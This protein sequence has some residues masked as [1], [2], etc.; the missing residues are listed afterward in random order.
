MAKIIEL[1]RGRLKV[2]EIDVTG[3]TVKQIVQLMRC[4]QMIGRTGKYRCL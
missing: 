2:A 3:W 4:Q 1:Y